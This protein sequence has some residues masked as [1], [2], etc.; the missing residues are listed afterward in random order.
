MNL[1]SRNSQIN[2]LAANLETNLV[3]I[4]YGFVQRT[5]L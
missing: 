1:V 5:T 2:K 4:L 3:D